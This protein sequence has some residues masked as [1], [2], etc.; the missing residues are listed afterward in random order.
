MRIFSYL[1]HLV[2]GLFLFV[3]GSIALF[4]SNLTLQMDM[5][6]WEDP[7]LTYLLFAGS[8]LGLASL[9]LAVRGKTRILF[10]VWTVVVFG[11]MAY[12]YFFTTLGFHSPDHFRNALLLT[13]GALVAVIGSWAKTVRRA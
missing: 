9:F 12:G 13:L 8:I 10:R 4:G 5:L 7:T 6:P 1:Y 11:F 2:L 3:V